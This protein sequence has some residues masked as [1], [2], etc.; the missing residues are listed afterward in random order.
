MVN[1]KYSKKRSIYKP[2]G[3]KRVSR[4][5]IYKMK[6]GFLENLFGGEPPIEKKDTP[7]P[8]EEPTNDEMVESPTVENEMVES[9]TVENENVMVESPT[10]ENEMVVDESPPVEDEMVVEESPIDENEMVE[11]PTDEMVDQTDEMTNSIDNSIDEENKMVEEEEEK[12]LVDNV[13]DSATNF[14]ASDE[15]QSV[16]MNQDE[17]S[18]SGTNMQVVRETLSNI[19]NSINIIDIALGLSTYEKMNGGGKKNKGTRKKR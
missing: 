6:G 16:P 18:L 15:T 13:V 3:S 2:T 9:P 7:Y 8:L 12:G 1:P 4:K 10:V 17:L 14:F 11:S 5:H 19:K